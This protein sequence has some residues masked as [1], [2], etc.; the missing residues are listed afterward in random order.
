MA[1]QPRLP[2]L[3]QA[4]LDEPTLEALFADI[5]ACTQVLAVLARP[6]GSARGQAPVTLSLDEARQ[7]LA[8]GSVRSL[9]IRYA[10]EGATWCDT[11]MPAPGGVRIVRIRDQDIA[12]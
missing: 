3:T 6:A 7:G 8:D 1:E 12:P 5:S 11:L 10:Y 4:L 9:Q 2:A